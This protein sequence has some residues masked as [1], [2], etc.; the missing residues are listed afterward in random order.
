M[1]DFSQLRRRTSSSK[2]LHPIELFEKLPN[3][4]GTPNDIW[5][6]QTE[7]L[8]RW[9]E[10]R[11]KKDVLVALNTGAGKTLVGLLIAQSLINEGVENVVYVCATI[12]LVQ[13]TSEQA[14]Q[15][16]LDYTTRTSG[17]YNNDLFESGRAFCITTYQALFNGLSSIRRKHFPGAVIFDDAHVAEG[18][19][20]DAL[21]LSIDGQS[22]AELFRDL[23]TLFEP[24]F[25]ELGRRGEFR[26]A[27]DR[28]HT[29]IVMAAPSGMRGRSERVLSLLESHGVAQNRELKFSF[30]HLR[31]RLDQCAVLF[32]RG[33]CE[34]T[35]PFLPSLATDVFE[36]PIRRVYLSA[37]L[38]SKADFVRA[39]GRLP[40]VAIE[41]RNDAGNG[42]RIVL[43]G[44]S[45]PDGV[46]PS[47][48]A[49]LSA[50]R[51]VLIAVPNYPAAKKW[52]LVAVPPA[53]AAFSDELNAFRK[54][55]A[56]I[57]VLVQRVDGIDLPHDT[58]RVMVL[59][60]LPAGASLLERY[61]WEFLGMR[62]LHGARIANRIVQ[63]FGRINRG[64][65]DYGAFLV[66]GRELNAWLN[67][68][69]NLALLPDLLQQQI[70]LGRL[71]QDEMEVHTDDAIA[72]VTDTVLGRDASWLSFYGENI[73][74]GTLDEDKVARANDAERR[75]TV[76]AAA[77]A[78]YA[79]AAWEGDR[80][81]ARLALEDTIE[82]AARGDT[83][84][85]GWHSIWLGAGYDVEGDSESASLA[86]RRARSLLGRNVA[87]PAVSV[88]GTGEA[89]K[90]DSPF[91]TAVERIVGITS[92]DKF[93]HELA[94][95]SK[96]LA[97]LNGASPRQ[98]EE[99]VRALGEA[100]GF[101]AS[102]PDNDVGTG[103][104][105]LW[106]CPSTAQCL[107]FELKT[108]KVTQATYNKKEVG[109]SL[110]SLNWIERQ[111]SGHTCLGFILVG[112][113]G[114][115][116]REANPS[117]R[118]WQ[119][120]PAQL[121]SV[122]DEL[123]AMIRDLREALPLERPHRINEACAYTG[124][125]LEA[126]ARRFQRKRLLDMRK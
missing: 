92:K 70:A 77:E 42:E 118:L 113:D 87:L 121:A 72:E 86:Y 59:D 17:S 33:F 97:D 88:T 56:G 44:R 7:A 106:S 111:A 2:P 39:F 104:D 47:L 116:T 58:C 52:E 51:K 122:R 9:H 53:K 34:L 101:E 14:R 66:N 43:F 28:E 40:E 103:P 20:R 1:R 120:P 24:H 115:C 99:A 109:Q 50:R 48:V 117:E 114:R 64:R 124:W 65:N 32:G 30:G 110:D 100:L 126:M 3:L 74:K 60:G 112:P 89:E 68:D 31:D 55:P 8:N 90:P 4:P 61:Q 41:P 18:M 35:P 96:R 83:L 82:D 63:L 108:D 37:T 13:Q 10:E 46:T 91:A 84:L 125:T 57:F 76:A 12:D 29:T 27:I 36:R 21:T 79:R 45:L 73:T 38:A 98:M 71:I 81:T 105:V 5:R 22:N 11:S 16:G 75:L 25:D 23:C 69:R 54:A 95:L 119:C 19:L 49:K 78:E 62:N 94:S 80:R 85:A 6:G 93:R 107:G 15:V 26:D 102:R 67:N 123:V